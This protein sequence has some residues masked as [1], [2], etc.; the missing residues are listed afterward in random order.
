MAE[1]YTNLP[2]VKVTYNDGNLYSAGSKL[3]LT[4]KSVLLIGSAI[5]GPSGEPQ[6]VR[7]MGIQEVDKLFG[8]MIDPL[9]KVPYE[10]SLVRSMYE[11]LNA[12]NDD[13]RLLRV[14]GSYAKTVLPVKDVDTLYSQDFGAAPGN[15]ETN[16]TF[17]F[18]TDDDLTAI[19]RSIATVT[20]VEE[21]TP[22]NVV[23]EKNIIVGNTGNVIKSKGVNSITF[24]ENMFTPGNTIKAY[25]DI[26]IKAY[27][28]V[29]QLVNN[30]K[31]FTD[32]AAVLSQDSN[33]TL[34][35]RFISSHA[36]RG[37]NKWSNRQD[38][39]VVVYVIPQGGTFDD[40]VQVPLQNPSNGKYFIQVGRPPQDASSELLVDPDNY[41]ATDADYAYGGI[42][43]TREY[44]R[45]AA[46]ANS[47]YP[48][49]NNQNVTVVCEYSFY[50]LTSESTTSEK[51]AAG[52]PIV[53]T[54]DFVPF[55]NEFTLFYNMGNSILGDKV[56]IESNKYSLN[57]I[58]KEITINAGAIPNG[59]IM[60]AD[61]RTSS[62]TVQSPIIEVLG[63]YPGKMYG[64][65]E[66]KTDPTSIQGVE[67]SVLND[68]LALNGK[69]RIIR[70]YKPAAKRSSSS[71]LKIEY[72]TVDYPGYTLR[73][74]AELVNKDS[75]NNIVKLFVPVEFGEKPLRGIEP[76]GAIRSVTANGETTLID[77]SRVFLGQVS[78]GVIKEEEGVAGSY[79]W[80]GSDGIYNKTVA[81]D[82]NAYFDLLG[83]K[84]ESVND[85]AVMTE[86][87][88][89]SMLENYAVDQIVLLDV[90]A[91]TL[92][93]P[94]KPVKNFATQLAQHCA[95]TTAKTWETIG[96]IGMAPVPGSTLS[97]I[98]EYVQLVTGNL[99]STQIS[100]FGNKYSQYGI[101][102]DYDNAHFM[103]DEAR[104]SY[105]NTD[106]GE[107]IDVGGYISVIMGPE[108]GLYS[109]KLGTYV[110]NG[111]SVYAG[112]VSNM[113]PEIS[114]TNKMVPNGKGLRYMFSEAQHNTLCGS[115]YVTFQEK[116][117][118]D[119]L[120]KIIVKDGVTAALS[121]SDYTRLSTMRIIHSVVQ[122]VRSRAE[123]F[124]G[125]PNGLAQRNALSAEI[126]L[127]LDKLKENGMINK[128]KFTIFS[129]AQDRVL[130]NAYIQLEV[131]PSFEVRKF[132]TS[133]VLRAM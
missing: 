57:L 82:M 104:F 71:D 41:E 3:S 107:R 11:A 95:T 70:F 99:S 74:F 29:P 101:R 6:S 58:D 46:E 39:P 130:G 78:Y 96:F 116:I 100:A 81:S 118:A 2:G 76:T 79:I 121:T 36:T 80:L 97:E 114:T 52:N 94:S 38:H 63:K 88:I 90:Y 56:V 22:S 4:T 26:N 117:T 110:T 115:R 61:Y 16:M 59:M 13:V 127:S 31:D 24:K 126:Q 93:D 89:Y 105:Q 66:D 27:E 72:R 119:N 7:T 129:S 67:V 86:Q 106:Q 75:R 45:A 87:G 48:S 128:F 133:V 69:E 47:P 43:F 44:D 33:Y 132:Y 98:Q 122:I 125:L 65:L 68:A 37:V 50:S 34:F 35:K 113:N 14:G 54:L 25:V 42:Y 77:E 60:K 112:M 111:V 83:G 92:I 30:I 62:Q 73:M 12:G 18:N 103:Y 23:T 84:Y 21:I 40:A 8:G 55:N 49:I 108:L 15:S 124:I 102:T 120:S 17:S 123:Q 85:V 51:L 53:R 9:T 109:E 20:K 64:Y 32:T 1:R 19:T 131:V 91:N 28:T 5:D 10:A